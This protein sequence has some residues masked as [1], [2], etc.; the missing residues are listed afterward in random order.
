MV[1]S[2]GSG[3]SGQ[4]SGGEN[5]KHGKKLNDVLCF[6]IYCFIVDAS[7]KDFHYYAEGELLLGMFY[8]T[9]KE[10]VKYIV[11]IFYW[12]Y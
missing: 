8:I 2:I 5:T 11:Y 1:Y 3:W 4:V 6:H 7:L 12:E 9:S 10:L